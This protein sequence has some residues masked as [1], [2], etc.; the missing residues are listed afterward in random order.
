MNRVPPLSSMRAFEAVAR[1]G[2]FKMAAVE[3]LV[4]PTAI[5]HQVRR[6]EESLGVRVLERSARMVSLTPEGRVLYEGVEAGF[7]EIGR[8]LASLRHMHAPPPITISSTMAFLG[9]WL[10]PRLPS[11]ERVLPGLQLRLH[12]SDDVVQL[13]AGVIDAAIRY[14][15][16]NAANKLATPLT[17]DAFGPVCS[18]SLCIERKADLMK[19]RLIHVDGQTRPQP[20]PGWRRWCEAAGVD[21][22]DPDAGT[23]LPS[24]MLAIQTAIAGRGIALVS[25]TLAA[26]AIAAGLLIRP[27]SETLP[28]DTFSFVVAPD[29][30]GQANVAT[31]R[32]WF[33]E[34]LCGHDVASSKSAG[35]GG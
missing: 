17:A 23:H 34:H 9:Q 15:S 25:L 2:S 27:F 33:E 28:G 1:L 7:T 14:G 13:S 30:S 16:P 29:V 21:N 5:S 3:L 8:A 32:R 4:T 31:L 12:A 10:V 24:T 35:Q 19:T 11:I 6:L 20:G 22:V 18:P 26:D